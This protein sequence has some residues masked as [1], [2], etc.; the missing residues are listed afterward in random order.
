VLT[1]I[2]QLQR[3]DNKLYQTIKDIQPNE[4]RLITLNNKNGII[5]LLVKANSFITNQEELMLLSV[6]DIKNQLDEKELESW[7]KLI[8]VM[9]HEIMNSITPITS[10]SET[11]TSFYYHDSKIKTS[12]EIDNKTIK[13][14][15]RGLE[16]IREQ[17]KSLISFVESYRKITRLPAPNKKIFP[18]NESD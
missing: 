17:G 1:H 12:E 3:L 7:R 18:G 2:N 6:H 16:V 14:T 15:V 10:L 11:L 9:M 5:Q 13:T 8:R 4:Q